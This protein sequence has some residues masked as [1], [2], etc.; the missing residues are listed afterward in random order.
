MRRSTPLGKLIK[1]WKGVKKE[2]TEKEYREIV[3]LI[4]EILGRSY[5]DP[6]W[7]PIDT[8]EE[9]I[10]LRIIPLKGGKYLLKVE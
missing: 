9:E 3:R 7:I 1:T 5:T 10:T 4:N 6:R 2:I 8:G